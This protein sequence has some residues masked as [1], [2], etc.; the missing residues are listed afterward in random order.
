MNRKSGPNVTMIIIILVV[1]IG[2]VVAYLY[3]QPETV[4]VETTAT[5]AAPPVAL[6][7]LAADLRTDYPQLA[8]LLNNPELESVYKDFYITY[9]NL[10]E[11]AALAMARQRGLLNENDDVVMTLV[12]DS[13][14]AA[15][16][17]ISQL[18]AEGVVVAGNYQELVDIV[19]PT[20]LILEQVEA[21]NTELIVERLSGLDHVIALR[22]P[23][24]LTVQAGDA[25]GQGVEVTHADQWHAQ[26]ITGQGV[27]VGIL[28]LGFARYESFLG[29]E[30]PQQVV[31]QTF[32]NPTQFGVQV[33]GTAV[34]EIVHAMA[35]DA[36]LYLAYF[37]GSPVTMA[38]AVDWLLSQGVDI[39]SNSTS[40]SGTTPMDGSGFVA[41]L[42]DKAKAAGVLWVSAAGNRADEHYRGVFRDSDGDTLHEF[43][44]G[45]SGLP[46]SMKAGVGTNLILSWNDWAAFNQDYDLILYDKSGNLLAK[47]ENFQGGQP[48]QGPFEVIFYR[49]PASDTYLLAV[50]N[51]GGQTRGDALLD[52][53][54]YNSTLPPEYQVGEGS[55]GTPADARGAFTVGAVNW[56]NDVLEPYSSQG[57]TRDGR[58]KPDMVAPSAVKSAAY[59][60]SIF[61]GTSAATPHISGAAALILQAD[62]AYT[63]DEV[64]NLLTNQAIKLGDGSLS[65]QFGAGRLNLGAGPP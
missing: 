53:F 10:G 14:E 57:P 42:A 46:F 31:V 37:D 50:Q 58:I 54:V 49:F 16:P 30:L 45:V 38:Q 59:A 25:V 4:A 19:I 39:I 40:I 21:G 56:A 51:R 1:V 34:A 44:P 55:L 61:D 60:P 13:P 23:Q 27:K 9:F 64:I 47:S 36:E 32:G 26:G 24:L 3:S 7:D 8:E 62:P 52:L 48:G 41:E 15:A 12:L 2:G 35:P 63:P 33:H 20:S 6:A 43:A 65:N 28:D 29:T 18:E 22:L 5:P 17:L 11:E